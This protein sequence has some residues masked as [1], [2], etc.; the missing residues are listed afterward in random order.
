VGVTPDARDESKGR[1]LFR[2]N[3]N[4][5]VSLPHDPA[6]VIDRMIAWVKKQPVVDDVD[7]T[8][9][10]GRLLSWSSVF[11]N[12]PIDVAVTGRSCRALIPRW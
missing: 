8:E 1:I 2:D 4:P 7:V 5:N 11:R 12:V 9:Y 3:S 6:L 10:K